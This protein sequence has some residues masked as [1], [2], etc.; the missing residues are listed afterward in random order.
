MTS[1]VV[2]DGRLT[3]EKL[4][5]LL[6]L[7][8]EHPEL[9]F[10][11]TL[12]LNQPAHRL[13][14]VKDLIAMANAGS[15]GYVII[16]AD[17]HGAPAS[18][19]SV[20]DPKRFDSADLGQLVAKYVVT[21]PVVTSQVHEVDGR[22]LV[23][24]HV[25]PPT[26][27]L[28][29]LISTAGE[30]AV[31][32]GMKTVLV[33]GVLYVRDGTRTV[34][35]TDAHWHRILSRYREG[36]VADT[37]G[38]I[39]VLVAKVVAGLGDVNAGARLAPLALEMEDGT[40][41]EA[42]Q[43]YFDR[44]DGLKELRRFLRSMR[45]AA[46][47][48]NDDSIVQSLALDKLCIVAIQAVM[49]ESRREFQL[50]MDLF[51]DLYM[52]SIGTSDPDSTIPKQSQ[53]GLEILLRLLVVGASLVDEEAWWAVESLVNR[54][55]SDYYIIW[56]RHALVHASRAGLLSGGRR[57]DSLVLVRARALALAN[58]TLMP[59]LEGRALIGDDDELPDNDALLNALC[60]FDFLWCTVT[61]ATHPDKDDGP[62]FYPSCAALKRERTAPI[63]DR[64]VKSES[65]RRAILPGT[66]ASVWK[67][68]LLRVNAVAVTQSRTLH[69]ITWWQTYGFDDYVEEH[70]RDSV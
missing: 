38:N 1:P 40:F 70:L 22:A 60:Q 58:P 23:L 4:D 64:L 33:E 12:D 59:T 3:R 8:A 61:V 32:K 49:A 66:P 69:Y 29:V 62:L 19:H 42:V 28:P 52:K 65:V 6:A 46:G 51:Y 25:A 37:R 30:Y 24:V 68:A 50:T 5:E 9:D 16:G 7:G 11:A 15:G 20:V 36:I 14:L 45:D 54:P 63:M 43:P 34:T 44:D 17:E 10:K 35:A 39:D 67:E 27:G 48:N 55:V 47:P 18:A 21:A 31:E 13:G 53:Y 41:S 57:E 26:S 56:L 2:V